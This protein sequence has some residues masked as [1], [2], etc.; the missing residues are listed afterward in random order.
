MAI[1]FVQQGTVGNT[2]SG[3]PGTAITSTL[4]APAAGNAI[5]GC[6]VSYQ[7][8]IGTS[9]FT[10]TQT[11]TFTRR[12]EQAAGIDDIG[13]IFSAVNIA[14]GATSVVT[15]TPSAGKYSSMQAMEV[16]GLGA[17]PTF[18]SA[19]NNGGFA[20]FPAVGPITPT[21]ADNITIVL[22]P[23]T[24]AAALG[25]VTGWQQGGEFTNYGASECFKIYYKIQSAADAVSFNY[26][27]NIDVSWS[28]QM[29]VASLD[30]APPNHVQAVQGVTWASVHDVQGVHAAN[31]KTI[32]TLTTGN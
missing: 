28:A 9:A 17:A 5:I 2:T 27:T 24:G 21:H 10:N 26:G 7:G 1:T 8:A 12:V 6:A 19:T 4:T 29:L 31:V 22:I 15:D 16:A 11:D 20:D 18:Q 32:N 14:G 30:A 23:N 25:A 13:A 3:T